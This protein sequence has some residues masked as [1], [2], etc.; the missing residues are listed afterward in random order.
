MSQGCEKRFVFEEELATVKKGL[1]NNKAPGAD[2][3]V[4]EILKYSGFEVRNKLLKIMKM[5]F[6]KGKVPNDFRKILIKPL[7]KKGD[8]SECCN[9]R[10]INLVSVCSKVL[11]NMI[12]FD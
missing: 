3:V 1:K 12:L 10:R 7:Y 2:S 4:N 8:K 5:I 9:Y 11:N 6:E